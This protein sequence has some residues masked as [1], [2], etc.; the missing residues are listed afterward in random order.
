MCEHFLETEVNRF[1][2]QFTCL[3]LGKVQNIIDDNEQGVSRARDLAD[4]AMLG[5]IESCTCEQMCQPHNSVHRGAN[6]MAH[7]SEKFALHPISLLG[8]FS[9]LMQLLFHGDAFGYVHKDTQIRRRL[10]IHHRQNR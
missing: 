1:D 4:V 7:I 10:V 5:F 2:P 3:N 9:G 6:F 8:K